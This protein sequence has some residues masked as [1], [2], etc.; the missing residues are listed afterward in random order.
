MRRPHAC[1]RGRLRCRRH[2]PNPPRRPRSPCASSYR[3][4]PVAPLTARPFGDVFTRLR[5]AAVLTAP[6]APDRAFRHARASPR[7]QD[8]AKIPRP[9]DPLEAGLVA[10]TPAFDVFG[11]GATLLTG[12]PGADPAAAG[13][14]QAAARRT[15]SS[16][17]WWPCWRSSPRTAR[18][19]RPSSGERERAVLRALDEEPAEVY[20][21][22]WRPRNDWCKN[23]NGANHLRRDAHVL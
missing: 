10:P 21:R 19:P 9:R 18:R 16:A 1:P 13:R 23:F 11:L 17:S 14:T 22:Q 6:R 7:P 20:L 8:R 15:T 12:T 2:R 4:A 3:P 5:L